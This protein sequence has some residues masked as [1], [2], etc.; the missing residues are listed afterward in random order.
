[1][2]NPARPNDLDDRLWVRIAGSLCFIT[3]NCHTHLGHFSVWV[4]DPGSFMSAA[5]SLFQ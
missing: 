5:K 1:M 4:D 2:S 3:G